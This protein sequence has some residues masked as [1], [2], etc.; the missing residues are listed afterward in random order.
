MSGTLPLQA[1]ICSLK[2][3]KGSPRYSEVG[4]T[5][6]SCSRGDNGRLRHASWRASGCAAGCAPIS[7]ASVLHDMES[8][9]GTGNFHDSCRTAVPIFRSLVS[10]RR[11]G[12]T[13]EAASGDPGCHRPV[14]CPNAQLTCFSRCRACPRG[15]PPPGS[16]PGIES[17]HS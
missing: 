7:G 9:A 1:P 10:L 8:V 11:A 2:H 14:R 12:P 13:A 4:L 15:F 17:G 3:C 5:A 6:A 16:L